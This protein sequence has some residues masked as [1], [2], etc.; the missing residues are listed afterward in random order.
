MSPIDGAPRHRAAGEDLPPGGERKIG[1]DQ[2]RVPLEVVSRQLPLS[3]DRNK[4]EDRQWGLLPH[5][6]PGAGFV[7]CGGL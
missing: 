6:V 1:G 3:D 5:A 4:Q 2:D 7:D